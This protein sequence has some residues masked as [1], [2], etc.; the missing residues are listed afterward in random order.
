[1][2]F[3]PARAAD[4]TRRDDMPLTRS[5]AAGPPAHDE[6]RQ[7]HV[8]RWVWLPLGIFL[9]ARAFSA[10]VIAWAG[11]FQVETVS[12]VGNPF[13]VYF[14]WHPMPADPGYLGVVTNWDGQ[15]YRFIAE[16][17]YLP[18]SVDGS[19]AA[20]WAWAYP[21][22]FPSTVAAA[23]R[24]TGTSF[25]VAATIV[26]IA[27]GAIAMVVMYR[28]VEQQTGPLNAV[29][30]VAATSCFVSSPLLQAAYSES[31]AL[32]LLVVSLMLLSRQRTWWA[33]LP[34]GLLAFTRLITPPLAVV[35]VVA[36]VV[37][38]RRGAASTARDW[39]ACAA[40]S[41]ASILGVLLWPTVAGALGGGTGADR[42]QT[43]TAGFH[44][45][46]FSAFYSMDPLTVTVPLAL[47]GVLCW[48]AYAKRDEWGPTLTAWAVA[49]PLFL[50]VVTPP[51]AGVVRYMLLAFPLGMLLSGRRSWPTSRRYALVVV[52]CGVLLVLQVVW[53]RQLLVYGETPLMP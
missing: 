13:D 53:I 30:A 27:A 16:A 15:W 38:V 10:V 44:L 22:G 34:T 47:A 14:V 36:M 48:A 23:M 51:L 9:L 35:A 41:L 5:V 20:G 49:Y 21:P 39:L 18:A 4:L 46:W 6:R 17:G 26:S 8:P 11:Q 24:L 52:G 1:M 45:G 7:W 12:K 29:A 43:M 31:M 42:V 33:L 40:F 19:I 2:R 3:L 28:Y 50:M 32:L 25:P 37:R